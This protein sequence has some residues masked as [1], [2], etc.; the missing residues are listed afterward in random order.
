MVKWAKLIANPSKMISTIEIPLPLRV[1][2]KFNMPKKLGFLESLFGSALAAK[3]IG[4]VKC[5]NGVIWKLDLAE[6]T[7]RWIVYGD[8]EGGSG[9]SFAKHALRNGGVFVDSGSNIGQWI[10]YLGSLAGVQ[11]LEFEPVESQRQWLACCLQH[12]PGW[13]F[14]IYP[15]GLGSEDC[16][17]E[18][19]CDGPRSTLR[20][21][22]FKSKNLDREVIEIRRLD[23][24]L[25]QAQINEVQ[26][27]K[28]DV[29]GAE[30]DAL[31]GARDYLESHRI[32]HIYF[33]CL[34]TNYTR[35]KA[36]LE[37]CGYQIYDIGWKG[38]QLK[39]DR[40]ISETQDL[41]AL[42]SR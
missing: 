24:V 34:H 25:K 15:Y 12:Q 11:S 27:W 29:E 31:V 8:Y 7:H 10:L 40:E 30:Y 18:I 5:S 6:P 4:W 1:I 13:N 20:N 14:T 36:F 37:M 33:E 23:D 2:R 38:L 3:G 19:Q 42:P 9:L 26:L 28:L 41:V 39:V 17:M 22:W 35:N 21:D 16:E 32:K